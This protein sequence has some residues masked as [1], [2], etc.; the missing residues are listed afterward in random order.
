MER[1]ILVLESPDSV[2]NTPEL[3]GERQFNEHTALKRGIPV[4]VPT[5][6]A[7]N[8]DR[9]MNDSFNVMDGAHFRL[10]RSCADPDHL[11]S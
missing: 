5:F 7:E 1:D 8:W 3:N 11:H 4:L 6:L 9:A 2:S 10:S